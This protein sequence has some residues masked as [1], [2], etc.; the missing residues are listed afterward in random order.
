MRNNKPLFQAWTL[1]I[2]LGS[3]FFAP[4]SAIPAMFS[5]ALIFSLGTL[6]RW[7]EIK[8][9]GTFPKVKHLAHVF[10]IFILIMGNLRYGFSSSM[11]AQV[12]E[13]F[14]LI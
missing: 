3:I 11:I 7:S 1:Y 13:H 9:L 2:F 8:A 10:F 5:V 4:V 14:H 6:N 12:L